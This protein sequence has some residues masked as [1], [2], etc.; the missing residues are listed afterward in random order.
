MGKKGPTRGFEPAC[1]LDVSLATVLSRGGAISVGEPPAD[2]A[3]VDAERNW[4]GNR[5]VNPRWLF[6]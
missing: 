3:C 5:R 6:E 4:D 1:Q 2:P